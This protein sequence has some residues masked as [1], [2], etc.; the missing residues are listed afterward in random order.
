[1]P[2]SLFLFDYDG[3]LCDTRQAILY[4]F[5]RTFA[6]YQVPQPV[7]EVV[8]SMIGRGLVLGDMLRELRPELSAEQV[9]E[10]VVTYRHIYAREAEP[11]VTPFPGA[12]DLFAQLTA[13]GVTIGVVSN[14]GA[15]VL[16]ASLAKLDLLPF[17]ALV[18]GDG[19][20]PEKQLA[21]KPDPMVFHQ[22]VQPRFPE[23]PTERIL[24]VGDTPAD[25]QFALNSRIDS[26]WVTFGFGDDEQC[27]A[28]H[29]THTV[30]HLLEIPALR[31]L[32]AHG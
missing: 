20:M 4:G 9:Q 30:S 24:M 3:T 13:Q 22:V 31:R 7:P 10:W 11:L 5:E 14:K 15:A 26:C 27:R 2:Y 16:E 17:V 25:L 23:V 18:I 1:M 8:Y 29:P 21:K 19:T 28:L 6:H 12:H 32:A